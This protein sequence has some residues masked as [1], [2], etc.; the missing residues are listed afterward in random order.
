MFVVKT[1]H[2]RSYVREDICLLFVE[3]FFIF[4]KLQIIENRY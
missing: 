3:H 1:I 2:K 4:K